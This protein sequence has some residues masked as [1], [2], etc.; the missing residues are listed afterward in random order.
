M[1]KI[2]GIAA[3]T[4]ACSAAQAETLEVAGVFAAEA[5]MDA[6]VQTIA[7]EGFGGDAGPELSFLLFDVLSAI[8]IQ[9]QNW[10]SIVPAAMLADLRASETDREGESEED[11]TSNKNW[12]GSMTLMQGSARTDFWVNSAGTKKVISCG[13]RENGDC[14]EKREDVY[15][16]IMLNVGYRPTVRLL[17]SD[18]RLLYENSEYLESYEK[19]CD[20]EVGSPSP[21]VLL[22]S[23]AQQYARSVRRDLAPQFRS[24]NVLLLERRKGMSKEDA[25]SFKEAVRLT[26]TDPIAACRAFETLES[27]NRAHVSVLFNIGLCRE[28]EDDLGQARDYY[29]RTLDIDSGKDQAR[30]G[31]D[32]VMSRMIARHQ[33]S[34][35]FSSY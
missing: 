25:R 11:K 26:K 9:G 27:T 18:G 32:R 28:S 12:L 34:E 6:R 16:C 8:E 30:A 35:H 10:F 15:Q 7:V 21:H 24:A 4:C 23:L 22:D 29:T 3:L 5:N 17:A 13:K 1:K 31:N 2:I 19:S 20:D 14:V 33:V